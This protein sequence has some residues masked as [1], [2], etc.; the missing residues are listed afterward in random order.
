MHT[1][2]MEVVVSFVGD[3]TLKRHVDHRPAGHGHHEHERH[4]CGSC[5]LARSIRHGG[6]VVARRQDRVSAVRV[7][8][9][10]HPES[11]HSIGPTHPQR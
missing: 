7:R 10:Y 4:T 5:H 8:E 6:L 1:H 2:Q 9:R 11:Q 3:V